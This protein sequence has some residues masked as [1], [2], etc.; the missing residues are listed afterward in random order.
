MEFLND[1]KIQLPAEFK[2][3]EGIVT[4]E[5]SIASSFTGIH[6]LRFTYGGYIK[7]WLDGKL[8]FDLWRKAW[9]PAPVLI[10]LE[11]QKDKKVVIKIEWIPEGSESYIS[12]K[13]L[14]PI[15]SEAKNDVGFVSEA[16]Q[17]LDYYFIYGKNIDEVIS[18]Y[19]L[20]TGKA[21]IVP[22]WAMGFWQK[23]GAL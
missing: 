5:G 16:G 1:S 23:Q 21:T 3:A 17:L 2:P 9:N 13:W 8:Q 12:F 11:M 22:Q 4:W 15:L 10:D 19:R 18:G 7:L 6:K 20:L 14:E